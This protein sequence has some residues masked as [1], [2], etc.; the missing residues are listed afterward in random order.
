V[1]CERCSGGGAQESCKASVSEQ[2]SFNFK[3]AKGERLAL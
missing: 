1:L 3:C 2:E